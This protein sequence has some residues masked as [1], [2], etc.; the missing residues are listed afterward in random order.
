MHRT[1]QGWVAVALTLVLVASMAASAAAT[2]TGVASTPDTDQSIGVS[3]A[4]D[5][6]QTD[7][8]IVQTKRYALTPDRPGSVRVTVTY[9]LPDRVG[10]LQTS[11]VNDGTVTDTDGFERVNET[12]YE[13]DE[14]TAAPSITLTYAPNETASTVGPV[15]AGGQY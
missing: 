7:D 1:N 10:S 9:E 6:T 11:L 14:S 5:A 4:A 8:T 3:A 12:S 13:W 2:Q 15:S